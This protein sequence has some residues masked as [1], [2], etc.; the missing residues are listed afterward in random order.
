MSCIDCG[1]LHELWFVFRGMWNVPYV[2][3]CY[4]ING[5]LIRQPKTKPS[6]VYNDLDADMAFCTNMREKVSMDNLTLCHYS[7]RYTDSCILKTEN[8]IHKKV[9]MHVGKSVLQSI[10]R[11]QTEIVWENGM[12]MAICEGKGEEVAWGWRNFHNEELPDLYC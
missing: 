5:T 2:T 6:Y 9:Y 12:L 7:A 10:W 3:G 11:T 1:V 8:C 4:L